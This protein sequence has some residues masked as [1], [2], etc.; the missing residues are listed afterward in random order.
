M[1]SSEDALSNSF[2][3]CFSAHINKRAYR[4]LT[5]ELTEQQSITFGELAQQARALATLLQREHLVRERVLVATE[6]GI[7]FIVALLACL[8][9]GV[10]AVPVPFPRSQRAK[11]RFNVISDNAAAKAVLVDVLSP[12]ALQQFRM[13]LDADSP[14]R[15]IMVDG[16]NL[17]NVDVA[18]SVT[19][20]KREDVAFIQYTSG[21]TGNAKGV[22]VS[23]DNLL[24]QLTLIAQRFGLTSESVLFSWLP[25]YHDMGLVGCLL[26]PLL[27][28]H[29]CNFTS[30]IN[31]IGQPMLWLQGIS[32]YKA[33][34]SGGP[35]FAYAL[36]LEKWQ[37]D[38]VRQ[39]DLSPW[40]VAFNGAE[41]VSEV[42]MRNFS[43]ALAEAGFRYDAFLPC[44]GLAEATLMVASTDLSSA[45]VVIRVDKERLVTQGEVCIVPHGGVEL[46]SSGAIAQPIDIVCLKSGLPLSDAKVG[47]IWVKGAS[48]ALGYWAAE[49]ELQQR[50]CGEISGVPGDYL[51]TGDAGFTLNGQLFV[52]GRLSDMLIVNGKNFPPQYLEYTAE[53]AHPIIKSHSCC[54]I[55]TEIEG[56]DEVV[57]I[58]ESRI[59]EGELLRQI[60]SAI[61]EAIAKEQGIRLYAVVLVRSGTLLRTSSGKIRRKEMAVAWRENHLHCLYQQCGAPVNGAGGLP[62]KPGLESTIAHIVQQILKREHINADD[63]FFELGGDS[64]AAMQLAAR[65]EQEYEMNIRLEWVLDNPTVAGLANIIAAEL[66]MGVDDMELGDFLDQLQGM[67]EAEIEQRLHEV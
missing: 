43:V 61:Q 50:F 22:M 31:F 5:K 13:A 45:P 47:E 15:V 4:F 21:S 51:K 10:V 59:R 63:S 25:P 55:Q 20:L 2:T 33:T 56:R 54:A 52:T 42:T 6:P 16:Q 11:A 9:A 7:A 17:E 44:Y 26:T 62:P 36:C 8:F 39:L 35:N 30:P 64:I 65:L 66:I 28:G 29:E 48:V 38:L 1:H 19:G 40:K 12:E 3:R 60:V 53:N 58:A 18:A 32:R 46:I 37:P 67:S 34:I 49:P 14:L 57:I 24:Q 23:R 27:V 41:P